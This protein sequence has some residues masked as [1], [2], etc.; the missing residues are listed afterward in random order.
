M[1]DE[2][3]ERLRPPAVP[4]EISESPSSPRPPV[5]NLCASEN[6]GDVIQFDVGK[7]LGGILTPNGVRFDADA[8][9]SDET[10]VEVRFDMSCIDGVSGILLAMAA[11]AAAAAADAGVDDDAD[12]V[13]G[14]G[15]GGGG[16]STTV[17]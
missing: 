9:A 11:T 8:L 5:A 13:V 14:G 16:L 6:G 3:G 2:V 12:D 17:E 7:K 4:F 15:G 10:R 1:S